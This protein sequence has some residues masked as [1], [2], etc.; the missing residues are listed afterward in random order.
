MINSLKQILPT[1]LNLA[2][3]GRL[4][5]LS[6]KGSVERDQWT[7]T[8]LERVKQPQAARGVWEHLATPE[9]RLVLWHCVSKQARHGIER[10]AL[11]HKTKLSGEA[12]D[13]ALCYL[14][15]LH[16]LVGENAAAPASSRCMVIAVA[17]SADALYQAGRELFMQGAQRST[18]SLD[19]LLQKHSEAQLWQMFHHYALDATGIRRESDLR[20]ALAESLTD[21][22][23][24]LSALTTLDTA[25]REVFSWLT[26]QGGKVSMQAVRTRFVLDDDALF[27]LLETLSAYGLAFD[28]LCPDGPD[29]RLLFVPHV[30]YER[31]RTRATTPHAEHLALAPLTVPPTMVNEGLPRLIG[32]LALIVN[33]VYQQRVELTREEAVVKR[34]LAKI[35][36]LLRGRV[37][38]KTPG[39]NTY[40]DMLFKM[41]E[42]LLLIQRVHPPF[43]IQS[44]KAYYETAPGLWAW[45]RLSLVEQTQHLLSWWKTSP[46]WQDAIGSDFQQWDPVGWKP[47]AARPLLVEAL[48][49]CIPGAWYGIDD[50]LEFL[51]ENQPYGLRQDREGRVQRLRPTGV[52]KAKWLCCEGAVL[53]G[54]LTSTLWELG[55]ISLGGAVGTNQERQEKA[56]AFQLTVLGAAALNL[57]LPPGGSELAVQS[58]SLVLLPTG[59]V[60]LMQF[61]T[62]TLYKLLPYVV[63]RQVDR[64]IRLAFTRSSINQ[65][66]DQGHSLEELLEFLETEKLPQLPQNVHYMLR[67]WAKN[68]TV[69][70]LKHA[71]LLSLSSEEAVRLLTTAPRYRAWGFRWLTPTTIAAPAHVH[72]GELR[73][74]LEAE[75][76]IVHFGRDVLSYPTTSLSQQSED[77]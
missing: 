19:K 77:G 53:R 14:F 12:L 39:E 60:L 71:L 16:L 32:D 43:S 22:D 20:A 66:I 55:L 68:Y 45:E 62:V 3:L 4:W 48:Q 38:E 6:Y 56:E 46:H 54:I 69:A 27:G 65:A 63:V 59:E 58:S 42:R 30:L 52:L 5:G 21:P 51:W 31:L 61:D 7:Q 50:L 9:E 72:L 40:S 13:A 15:E 8:L 24:V 70:E 2:Q 28:T 36:P 74:A 75:G 26:E 33:T 64:S 44:L 29:L 10:V 76:I 11:L 34:C 67:D 1:D 73:R 37:W 41:A 25:V 57:A 23:L 35:Q 47:L 49:R 17:D 18:M